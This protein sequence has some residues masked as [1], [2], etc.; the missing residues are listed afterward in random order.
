[1]YNHRFFFLP[2]VVETRDVITDLCSFYAVQLTIDANNPKHET[3]ECA[4]SYYNVATQTSLLQL[5]KDALIVSKQKGFDV[6]Y[7]LDVMHNESFF[8]DLKFKLD[9]SQ[10]HYYLY[11]RLRSALNPSEFGIAF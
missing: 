1:M 8:K 3:V 6:L 4:Y 2:Y 10:M 5:M 9:Y 7:A 11:N